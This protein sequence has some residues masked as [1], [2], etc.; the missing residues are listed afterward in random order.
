M[1]RDTVTVFNLYNGVWNYTTL[2][3]VDVNTNRSTIVKRYGESCQDRM[4]LHINDYT[5]F[6]DPKLYVGTGWTLKSGED[7]SFIMIGTFT[8][9]TQINDSD[10]A[11]GFYNYMNSTNDVY[12][13][14]NVEHYSVIPHI[15]VTAR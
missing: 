11:T 6:V 10:Y 4:A 1:Y 14:T 3:N 12:L 9:Q 15:E 5:G 2:K 8:S 7:A 13:V